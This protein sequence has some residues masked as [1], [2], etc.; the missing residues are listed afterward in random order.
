M[1]PDAFT[2]TERGRVRK[3]LEGYWAFHPTEAAPSVTAG[4]RR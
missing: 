4:S 1:R 3:A 2:S